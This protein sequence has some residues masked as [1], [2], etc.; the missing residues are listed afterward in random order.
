MQMHRGIDQVGEEVTRRGPKLNPSH[1]ESELEAF[2]SDWGIVVPSDYRAFIC[3]I[4]NGGEGPPEYGLEL[5]GAGRSDDTCWRFPE[6]FA[7]RLR[8]PFGETCAVLWEED[9][10]DAITNGLLYLG[11]DG[12]GM[13]WVL[14]VTGPSRGEVWQLTEDGIQPCAP[15][16]TFLEWYG[17]WLDGSTDW[18]H[19]YES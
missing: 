1:A 5:L 13:Y 15:K 4:G 2:E 17:S 18:W 19:A 10:P 7:Y 9:V 16:L 12:N 6:N 14:V 8:K 11:N 3:Q